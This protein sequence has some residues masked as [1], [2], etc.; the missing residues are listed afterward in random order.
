MRN[1]L[2]NELKQL[3]YLHIFGNKKILVPIDCVFENYKASSE[4]FQRSSE[5]DFKNLIY[6]L[7]D[8]RQAVD[9]YLKDIVFDLNGEDLVLAFSSKTKKFDVNNAKLIGVYKQKTKIEA[10]DLLVDETDISNNLSKHNISLEKN[11]VKNLW[12]SYLCSDMCLKK[13]RDY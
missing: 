6:E 8:K 3:K 2:I 10:L 13:L 7:S 9:T 5:F 4:F 1:Y 11:D 12:H